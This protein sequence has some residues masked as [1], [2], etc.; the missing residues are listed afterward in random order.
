MKNNKMKSKV[1]FIV[2]IM[3]LSFFIVSGEGSWLIK[4]YITSDD[5]IVD[6]NVEKCNVY[7]KYISTESKID[8][9]KYG[10]DSDINLDSTGDEAKTIYDK[11]KGRINE[12]FTESASNKSN[13]EEDGVIIYTWT[14]VRIELTTCESYTK[15]ILWTTYTYYKVIGTRRTY[16]C[17]QTISRT[18]DY[19][20]IHHK[21]SIK[22]GE[23]LT[24]PSISRGDGDYKFM[25]YLK[26]QDSNGTAVSNETFDFTE[27]ITQDTYIFAEWMQIIEGVNKDKENAL[28]NHINNLSGSTT[29][30]TYNSSS[31]T[32]NLSNDA[33]YNAL[34]GYV[35]LGDENNSTTIASNVIV[36]FALNSGITNQ[37][38]S[39]KD[40]IEDVDA[41]TAD[42]DPYMSLDYTGSSTPNTKD[43]EVVLQNDLYIEADGTLVIGGVTG[44]YYSG[45]TSIQ[46]HI[47]SNYVK[48]D[49][50][51]HNIYVNGTLH[52]YGYIDDSAGTGKII[53]NPGGILKTQF[54]IYGN[55]GGNHTLWAYSKGVAPFE[56]YVLP[57]I[58]CEVNLISNSSGSGCLDIF[59]KL[60]LGSLGFTNFYIR[61][62]GKNSSTDA[63]EKYFIETTAKSN[64][65]GCITIK[66]QISTKLKEHNNNYIDKNLVYLENNI[67]IKNIDC[68]T[69]DVSSKARV[70]IDSGIP[71]IGTVDETFPLQLDRLSFPISPSWNLNFINSSLKL[72]QTLIFMPGSSMSMDENSILEFDY[73]KGTGTTAAKK[74]FKDIS[75][76]S[77]KTLPGETRYA[78]GGIFAISENPLGLSGWQYSN[79]LYGIYNSNYSD[80]WNY[81]ESALININGKVIFNSGNE[82]P[83]KLAGN[84][85]INNYSINNGSTVKWNINNAKNISSSN[86]KLQTYDINILAVGFFWFSSSNLGFT[87]NSS[88]CSASQYFMSPLISNDEAYIV[89]STYS[90]AM[91]GTW[92][93]ELGVFTSSSGD[94]YFLKT[95]N[96][97]LKDTSDTES[98]LDDTLTPTKCTIEYFDKDNNTSPLIVDSG[99]GE[100][101]VYY[102]GYMAPVTITDN[103]VYVNASKLTNS[104]SIDASSIRIKYGAKVYK[105][106]NT[107]KTYYLWYKY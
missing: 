23:T 50:N 64:S 7:V 79:T 29:S 101:F 32:F 17:T 73:Y 56:H 55:Q 52:S 33:S 47:I 97:I 21:Y 77:V 107:N 69:N 60:N 6:S 4:S 27:P 84:I 83:Y 11:A 46:G 25:G 67:S 37:E 19:N 82:E 105:A 49:L 100:K 75:V 36:N 80:Y 30:N 22:K 70:F 63:T 10:N 44:A 65:D 94:N 68:A 2:L 51:G 85:N 16:E 45:T 9:V 103:V 88:T 34:T 102:A 71:L 14:E 31:A 96:Q 28:T 48:L 66:P 5:G 106:Y 62:F 35:E 3:L 87:N 18:P 38:A 39:E 78:S 20:I 86:V 99:T 53:V 8:A 13:Y 15:K 95:N 58:N 93:K 42:N 12:E 90:N 104:S 76:K 24:K 91:V 92:S 59:T 57:Y 26:S 72:S 40:N 43:Y 74:T 98:Q 41:S 89:D 81:Y 61:L 1:L 54:V